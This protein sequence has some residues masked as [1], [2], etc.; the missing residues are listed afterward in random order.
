MKH[1]ITALMLAVLAMLPAGAQTLK[2][3]KDKT[4]KLFGYQ[5]ESKAWV[6]EPQF[7][8]AKKFHGPVAEV[9]QKE[10]RHKIWGVIDMTGNMVIPFECEDISINEKENH[11]F[12][13]RYFQ[14]E[15]PDRYTNTDLHAWGVYDL[16]GNEIWAPQFDFKPT[17][18]HDGLAVVKDRA[19]YM[20]GIVDHDG[21]VV[22][23][24]DNFDVSSNLTGFEVLDTHLDKYTFNAGSAARKPS[25]RRS[26][27]SY[28]GAIP[29]SVPYNT[30]DDDVK[31]A[32]YGHRRLGEKLTYNTIFSMD[33]EPDGRFQ[34]T[35]GDLCDYDG[36]PVDWGVNGDRFVRLELDYAGDGVKCTCPDVQ[37]GVNYTV[38][39]NL[40][41]PDGILVDCI[42]P[43]GMLY[44]D[45]AQGVVYRTVNGEY[46][47]IA[48]D[49]NWPCETRR[50]TLNV[51]GFI[52]DDDIENMM[53]LTPAEKAD[54]HDFWKSGRRH[55]EV[56]LT[57]IGAMMTYQAPE[58]L[59][60]KEAIRYQAYLIDNYNFLYRRYRQGQVYSIS[61]FY[62]TK[63]DNTVK[64]EDQLHA[65]ITIDY[66]SGL[67]YKCQDP[68]FW[69]PRGDRY[70]RIIPIPKRYVV[71][72][73]FSDGVVDDRPE[74]KFVITFEFR[75][76]EDD[77]TFVQ[78]LGR[79]KEIWFGD[80]DIVG[81]KGVDWVFTRRDPYNGSIK[82]PVRHD[83]FTGK[84]KDFDWVQF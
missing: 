13:D 75:L 7:S 72:P 3:V 60:N 9:M 51:N 66:S 4:T 31:A 73:A 15:T 25:G 84:I 58:D 78:I 11:I 16:E 81:F 70:I 54:L 22:L 5:D 35:L 52:P 47:F 6:I 26:G 63:T 14:L 8:N 28:V 71:T 69:G 57:D 56:Q 36:R 50:T 67:S 29:C 40:Y 80:T 1:T 83:T 55:R 59:N 18:N 34:T 48:G 79:S 23:P 53:G 41:E 27:R 19:T 49:I 30:D 46:W 2:P 76:Y 24:L 43:D 38:V 37:T 21:N 65:N 68:V 10:E 44:A 17:F 82:F 12:A 32:A 33:C 20:Y 39:A 77:G 62:S 42:C 74:S 61:G 64:V 45:L